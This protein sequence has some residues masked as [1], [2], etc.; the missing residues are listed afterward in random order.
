[1]P[2]SK[3]DTKPARRVTFKQPLEQPAAK[4]P[5]DKKA[6]KE[7]KKTI[8]K[9]PKEPVVP[10]K[11]V[12][13]KTKTVQK[14]PKQAE[15]KRKAGAV[16]KNK[17]EAKV[18]KMTP[19]PTKTVKRNLSEE[20]KRAKKVPSEKIQKKLQALKAFEE[21]AD[22]S[23]SD[24]ATEDLRQELRR[25]Q[26]AKAAKKGNMKV[27]IEKVP[28]ESE[29]E[30]EDGAE[31]E[32]EQEDEEDAEDEQEQSENEE[33]SEECQED[34]GSQEPSDAEDE[35]EDEE[36]EQEEEKG[37]DDE[38]HEEEDDAQEEED[39]KEKDEKPN[40][41]E[42]KSL[43]V[44][45]ASSNAATEM[46]RNSVT[47]ETEWD[48]FNRAI[49]NRKTFPAEMSSY[50]LKNKNEVFNAWLDAGGEWDE[51][52]VIIERKQKSSVE[53]LSGWVAVKGKD[54]AA[55]YGDTKAQV[56]FASCKASGLTYPDEDFPDDDL[57]RWYY[58]RKGKELT[59]REITEEQATLSGTSK[60][61]NKMLLALTDESEGIF[62]AG[63]V[64]T[65][66][67][68]STAGQKALVDAMGEA[69]AK[70]VPRRLRARRW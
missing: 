21:E 33:E 70:P 41:V 31:E 11:K 45:A 52:K 40:E 14:E 13:S 32:Q 46:V 25:R 44:V 60:V 34:E 30:D 68:A 35:D 66:Q 17:K 22:D 69:G 39:E 9:I 64:P 8:L 27:K 19:K 59:K 63:Q 47:N 51:C 23:S 48:T 16:E 56:V 18:A 57:E 61:D 7:V 1:M 10:S 5:K 15:N 43:A 65:L 2:K 26:A 12:N 37:D 24:A 4:K 3:A 6:L 62:K 50:V 58:M 55:S 53:G 20:L 67:A 42:A 29:D 54:I 49:R 36:Q 38:E 28:Q